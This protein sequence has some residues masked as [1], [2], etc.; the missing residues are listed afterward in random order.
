M[1]KILLVLRLEYPCIFLNEYVWSLLQISLKFVPKGPINNISELVKIMA[2]CL[3]RD[4]S[5]SQPMMVRLLTHIC[6]TRPQWIKKMGAPE[7]YQLYH[8]VPIPHSCLI[9]FVAC[10]STANLLTGARVNWTVYYCY[11]VSFTMLTLG[12]IADNKINLVIAASILIGEIS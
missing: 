5:L 8:L 10:P 11:R 12:W 7:L 3:H 2:W 6:V 9:R 1:I 4:K